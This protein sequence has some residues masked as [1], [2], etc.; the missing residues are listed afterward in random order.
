M[1]FSEYP[2]VFLNFYNV[3]YYEY[4]K[5]AC[6]I[7]LLSYGLASQKKEIETFGCLLRYGTCQNL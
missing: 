7:I 5:N 4:K 1:A 2:F 6:R 3:I